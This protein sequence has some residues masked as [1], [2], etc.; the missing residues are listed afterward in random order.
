MENPFFEN[1][2]N[3]EFRETKK[4]Q[5]AGERRVEGMGEKER[6]RVF[7]NYLHKPRPTLRMAC[8]PNNNDRIES[9]S[10]KF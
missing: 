9:I 2:R 4:G 5:E 7:K 3:M 10:R 6:S 8:R 1:N